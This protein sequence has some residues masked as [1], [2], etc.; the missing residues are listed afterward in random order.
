MF[1]PI[2]CNLLD[3]SLVPELRAVLSRVGLPLDDLVRPEA[4]EPASEAR[5]FASATADSFSASSAS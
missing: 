3:R 2:C 5:S 1:S 4:C